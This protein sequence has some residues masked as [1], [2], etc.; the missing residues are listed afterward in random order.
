MKKILFALAMVLIITYGKAQTTCATATNFSSTNTSITGNSLNNTVLW[1]KFTGDS[2]SLYI[3]AER[4]GGTT[5][6]KKID[7]YSGTCAGLTFKDSSTSYNDTIV[8]LTVSGLSSG[9]Q[10]YIK[11]T[12]LGS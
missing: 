6:L 10:Y 11:V 5:Y 3:S 2:S 12:P 7:V 8:S 9:V 4:T 1:F